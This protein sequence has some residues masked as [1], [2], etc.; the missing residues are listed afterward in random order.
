MLVDDSSIDNFVSRKTIERSGFAETVLV[1]E[2]AAT[3]LHYLKACGKKNNQA[4]PVPD[5]IFLDLN[6]P[7]MDGHEFLKEFGKLHREIREQS[8]IILLSSSTNL[9]DMMLNVKNEYVKAFFSKPLIKKNLEEV[10]SELFGIGREEA[11]LKIA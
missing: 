1:Y 3:A 5:I 10:E 2:S 8:K 6:M 4:C 11:R 9:S 7:V